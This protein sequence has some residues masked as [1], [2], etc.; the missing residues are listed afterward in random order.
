[1]RALIKPLVVIREEGN[2]D[3]SLI[4]IKRGHS[5]CRAWSTPHLFKKKRRV[6]L[7]GSYRTKPAG[8]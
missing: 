8:V 2:G 7:I 6:A 4:A 5:F 1:M 3:V